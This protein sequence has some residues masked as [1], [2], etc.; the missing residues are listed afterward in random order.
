MFIESTPGTLYVVD[1]S[2]AR[3]TPD[4]KV[5]LTAVTV[6]HEARHAYQHFN[7]WERSP[8]W[9]ADAQKWGAAALKRHFGLT[10]VY[11]DA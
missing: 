6:L 7:Q 2:H 10:I 1:L 9:E 3:V 5:K 4:W 11:R 8:A